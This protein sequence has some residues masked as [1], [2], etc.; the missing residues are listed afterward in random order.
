MEDG[1]TPE[2]IAEA[3]C[4]IERIRGIIGDMRTDLA[5]LR[6]DLELL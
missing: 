4:I 6:A 3:L 1:T 5:E 2:P